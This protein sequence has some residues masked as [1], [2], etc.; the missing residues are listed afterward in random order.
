MSDN[1]KPAYQID[2]QPMFTDALVGLA[3]ELT[4]ASAVH[5]FAREVEEPFYKASRS[6]IT[7]TV[8][9]AFLAENVTH[10]EASAVS[11]GLLLGIDTGRRLAKDQLAYT[12]HTTRHILDCGLLDVCGVKMNIDDHTLD[13]NLPPEFHN[14]MPEFRD[15]E[16][17]TLFLKSLGCVARVTIDYLGVEGVAS[18]APDRFS[19]ITAKIKNFKATWPIWA[20]LLYLRVPGTFS[21]IRLPRRM[22]G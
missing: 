15:A 11:Y 8:D 6:L 17:K 20:D 19:D 13:L 5:F 18:S 10:P 22:R 9:A 3:S 4:P 1:Q 7:S 16:L 21:K 12:Q 14:R 2:Y